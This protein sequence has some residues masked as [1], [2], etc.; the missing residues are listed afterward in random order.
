MKYKTKDTKIKE[1]VQHWLET[2]E[3][4]AIMEYAKFKM[5]QWY[6]DQ[7]DKEVD[8]FYSL[9]LLQSKEDQSQLKGPTTTCSGGVSIYTGIL[10]MIYIW[11]TTYSG[12]Q[13][14]I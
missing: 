9:H 1:M 2:E 4:D 12:I 6:K 13:I 11:T 14:M 3:Q 5:T 10:A 7:T 8:E